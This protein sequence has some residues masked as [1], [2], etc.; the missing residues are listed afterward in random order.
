M[1]CENADEHFLPRA[2]PSQAL[3]SLQMHRLRIIF[4][5]FQHSPLRKISCSRSSVGFGYVQ[6]ERAPH[7]REV[8]GSSP[9]DCM[10]F[11]FFQLISPGFSSRRRARRHQRHAVCGHPGRAQAFTKRAGARAQSWDG[12]RPFTGIVAAPPP[13]LAAAPLTTDPP[14]RR[15]PHSPT[16]VS[17]PAEAGATQASGCTTRAAASLSASGTAARSVRGFAP[18]AAAPLK[19]ADAGTRGGSP[20]RRRSRRPCRASHT[21]RGTAA[22]R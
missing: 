2:T 15:R 10:F 22:H 6:R 7:T 12:A 14:C 1:S 3:S 13:A 19:P 18:A 11:P 21:S 8:V 16:S 5:K 9:T 4:R 17:R 20:S